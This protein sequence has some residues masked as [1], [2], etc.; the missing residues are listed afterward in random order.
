MPGV[1]KQEVIATLQILSRAA[2]DNSEEPV[3]KDSIQKGR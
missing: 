1:S 2:S 3:P